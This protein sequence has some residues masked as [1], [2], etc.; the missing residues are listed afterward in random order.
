[1][2]HKKIKRF[3]QSGTL[4]DKKYLLDI[5]S[6][7]ENEIMRGMRDSGYVPVLDI[8]PAWS[9][10]MAGNNYSYLLTVHGVYFG[11]QRAKHVYGVLGQD[12]IPME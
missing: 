4:K 5:R 6:R 3:Q 7:A 11:K 1:M 12:E 10:S 2:T 8:T 9:V